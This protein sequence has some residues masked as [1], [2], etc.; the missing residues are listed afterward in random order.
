[1]RLDKFLKVSRLIKRRTV[2]N[3]LSSGGGVTVNGKVAK[4]STEINVGDE[5]TLDLG[6][7]VLTVRVEC[8][9][10]KAVPAQSAASLYTVIADA[11]NGPHLTE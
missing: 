11:Y 6:R 5:L 9:P 8:V 7:R 1:M 4:P 2:A 3:E 10:E